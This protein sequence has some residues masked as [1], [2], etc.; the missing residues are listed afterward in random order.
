MATADIEK[1]L[2]LLEKSEQDYK[3]KK[4][5]LDDLLRNDGELVNLEEKAKEAKKRH[6]AAKEAVLNEPEPRKLLETMKELAQEIKDTKKLLADELLAY[7]IKNNTLEYTDSA[8]NK[9]RIAVSA[10]FARGKDDSEA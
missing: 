6:S 4:E 10:K 9:R 8:G 5:M 7:F 3:T 1:R 2:S